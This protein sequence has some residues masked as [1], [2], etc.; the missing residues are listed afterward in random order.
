MPFH[1][2][3][4]GFREVGS[5]DVDA[6]LIWV[7]APCYVIRD[8]DETRPSSLGKDWFGFCDNLFKGRVDGVTNFEH[9]GGFGGMG[10][11]ISTQFGDFTY[12]VYVEHDDRG[13]PRRILIDFDPPHEDG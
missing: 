5:V 9:D 3:F 13:R 1:D 12:P 7:G 6:G 8:S 2:E 11:A 10:L 4:P